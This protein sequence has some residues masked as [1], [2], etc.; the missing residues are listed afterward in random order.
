VADGDTCNRD[1]QGRIQIT[2]QCAELTEEPEVAAEKVH[3]SFDEYIQDQA[4]IT[5]RLLWQ[6][7]FTP[8]G[9]RILKEC[10]RNNKKLRTA[11]DGSL[12]PELQLA[13]FRWL[14]IANGNV[15]VHGSG[16]VD[17]GIP[18]LLSS[19]RAELFGYGGIVEFLNHFCKFNNI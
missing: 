8:G 19:T 11:S 16:P 18:D 14:L 2:V 4:Q 7:E 1:F 13:S 3:W 5:R 6:F 17:D 12:D 10:L 9:E 15:L